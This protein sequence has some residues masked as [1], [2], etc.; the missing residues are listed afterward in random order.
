M[1]RPARCTLLFWSRCAAEVK[2]ELEQRLL[3]VN[4]KTQL[5]LTDLREEVDARAAQVGK[6][7]KKR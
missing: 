5:A 2:R 7:W 1:A 3:E 4:A 6:I